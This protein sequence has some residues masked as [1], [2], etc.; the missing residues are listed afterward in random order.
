MLVTP[1]KARRLLDALSRID[2]L[3]VAGAELVA[4]LERVA[5]IP[6]LANAELGHVTGH[7]D[8]RGPGVTPLDG[9]YRTVIVDSVGAV[10]M[11]LAPRQELALYLEL[12]GRLNKRR[13]RDEGAYLFSIGQAAE[14]VADVVVAAQASGD[15]GFARELEAA[16]AREQARRGLERTS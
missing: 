14:L 7:G 13:D 16:I 4:E 5:A 11:L 8:G 1:T 3:D 12:A 15:T 9:D 6:E 10:A 2:G